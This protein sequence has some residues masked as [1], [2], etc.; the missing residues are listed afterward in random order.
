MFPAFDSGL[1]RQNVGVIC[2]MQEGAPFES[3]P[4]GNQHYELEVVVDLPNPYERD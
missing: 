4:T 3:A 2:E 1:N